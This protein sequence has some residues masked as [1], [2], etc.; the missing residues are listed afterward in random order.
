MVTLL[1]GDS[2]HLTYGRAQTTLA[3]GNLHLLINE[4]CEADGAVFA[5]ELAPYLARLESRDLG[6]DFDF[7]FRG[8][9][10]EAGDDPVM[11]A[12]QDAFFDRVYWDPSVRSASAIGAQTALG[13]GIVYDSRVHG[14][15]VRMRNRTNEDSGELGTVGEEAWFTTY[16]ATRRD[17]LA[18]HP[19]Q[20]L[21][22]TVYRMDAF[23]RLI[24][25]GAWELALPLTVRGVLID[26]AVLSPPLRPSAA[27]DDWRVLKL[28]RPFMRGDDVTA[29]QEALKA[30][31]IKVTVDGIFGPGTE[32][33][34]I[35]FQIREG[36]TV[37][38]IAGPATR[39]ALE[40]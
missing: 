39:A 3:S 35:A 36:L 28:R 11:Q 14:S 23:S 40:G 5:A 33:A 2:G 12:V 13:T 7:D 37:D 31:G 25:D 10:R 9:L 21:N 38:G 34:V 32:R 24:E 20:L 1:D 26:E 8:M 30:A 4:Y 16:I 27:E 29:L 15:W 18:T 17:W 19:N 22:R 6:L